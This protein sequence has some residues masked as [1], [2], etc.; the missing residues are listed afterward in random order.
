[1][2][3]ILQ[4]FEPADGIEGGEPAL[5]IALRVRPHQSGRNTDNAFSVDLLQR[6]RK[7]T[8]LPV[9]LVGL[10]LP[11][12][13][14]GGVYQVS[15]RE[16]LTRIRTSDCRGIITPLTG[17]AIAAWQFTLKPK[18]FVVFPRQYCHSIDHPGI[19]TGLDHSLNFS[20]NTK[21]YCPVGCDAETVVAAAKQ[22]GLL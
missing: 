18:K 6:I 20:G 5:F 21:R 22:E 2:R 7:E 19:V 13:D 15:L 12:F 16:W 8:D 3:R 9:Y 11:R 1:L 4:D 14:I 17:T 10:D